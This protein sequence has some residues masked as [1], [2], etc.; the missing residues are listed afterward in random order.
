MNSMLLQFID[1]GCRRSDHMAYLQLTSM[2]ESG[3]TPIQSHRTFEELQKGQPVTQHCLISRCN[4]T[5]VYRAWDHLRNWMAASST[6]Q[7]HAAGPKKKTPI[8]TECG[9]KKG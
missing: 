6:E 8:R 1:S 5:W 9:Q 3:E 7:K 4:L 2:A